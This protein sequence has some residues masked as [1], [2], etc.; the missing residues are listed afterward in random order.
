M[1]GVPVTGVGGPAH[2]TLAGDSDGGAHGNHDD[3][4]TGFD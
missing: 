1:R 2:G 3:A 4:R